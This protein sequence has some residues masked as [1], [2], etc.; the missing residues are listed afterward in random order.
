MAFYIYPH[1][2]KH[3]ITFQRNTLIG[4]DADGRPQYDWQDL[5]STRAK[6]LDVRGNEFTQA[7][8]VGLNLSK[9]VYVRYNHAITLNNN[10]RVIYNNEEY[11]I[12]YINNF[13]EERKWL[14]IKLE[15]VT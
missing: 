5:Y 13:D 15:R 10:D 3:P 12:I 1:E 8:G 9:T 4:K 2:F 11:N 6:I 14:E 7:Y